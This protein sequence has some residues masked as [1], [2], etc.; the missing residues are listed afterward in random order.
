[1]KKNLL[2][3]GGILAVFAI[4]TVAYILR[5]PEEAS[6]PIESV[7]LTLATESPAAEPTAAEAAATETPDAQAGANP[8]AAAGS[9]EALTGV[10]LFTISQE[11]SE[12]RFSIDEILNN[13]A[14]TAVGVSSQVAGEIA[15]D[16]D[17]PAASQVGVITINA[18]TLVTDR[19]NRNRMIQNEILDT[20]EHEFITFTPTSVAGLPA[21]INPGET[22]HFQITGDLQIR[23][24]TRQITFDVTATVDPDGRLVGYAV[25]TVLRSDFEIT[26][27]SVPSVAE[28][29]DEVLLEIDFVAVSE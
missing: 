16:F 27:P 22:V 4:L 6:A 14:V 11:E 23:H 12:V 8:A 26:I 18:R 15:I 25:A 13:E 17:D 3:G 9:G 2:I 21:A 28:V 10:V 1:M 7:P 5:P 29:S 24:I 19:S 20:A